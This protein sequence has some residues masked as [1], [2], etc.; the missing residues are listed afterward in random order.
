MATNPVIFTTKKMAHA[1]GA[2]DRENA[3]MSEKLYPVPEAWQKVARVDAEAY[4]ALYPVLFMKALLE[5]WRA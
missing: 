4:A 2:D 3:R 5:G 1:C